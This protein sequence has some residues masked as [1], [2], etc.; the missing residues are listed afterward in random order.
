MNKPTPELFLKWRGVLLWVIV[1]ILLFLVTDP[2][3][4]LSKTF[5][6]VLTLSGILFKWPVTKPK[7]NHL[8]KRNNVIIYAGGFLLWILIFIDLFA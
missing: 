4:L 7:T 1:G 8:S 2:S 3:R 6:T 5:I